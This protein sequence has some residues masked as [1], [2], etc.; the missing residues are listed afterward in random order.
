V[1]ATQLKIKSPLAGE[2]VLLSFRQP[3]FLRK[4][5]GNF[6]FTPKQVISFEKVTIRLI[7]YI[8]VGQ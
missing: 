1:E 7:F 4:K 5:N 3:S 6:F 2:R 8:F